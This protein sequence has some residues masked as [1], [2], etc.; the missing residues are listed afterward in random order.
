MNRR[1]SQT[2][3][4]VR[5]ARL[6]WIFM[7]PALAVL[8]LIAT[9]PLLATL[10]ESFHDH[11]LRLPWLGRRFVGLT[12]YQ[13]AATDPRFQEALGHTLAFTLLTV[14][15]ELT[16]GLAL[17]LGLDSLARGRGLARLVVLL[18]GAFPTVVAGLVWRF[19]FDSQSGLVNAVVGWLGVTTLQ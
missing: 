16:L 3:L 1:S 8:L 12:N 9:A 17:A 6:A 2:L 4:G 14:S 5:E 15:L 10:W 13:E 19:I 7:G 18:P 11:D